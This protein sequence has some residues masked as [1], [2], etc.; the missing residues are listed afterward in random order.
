MKSAVG[1]IT[2]SQMVVRSRSVS[3]FQLMIMVL[4]SGYNSHRLMCIITRTVSVYY[5]HPF[6]GTMMILEPMEWGSARSR[7]SRLTGRTSNEYVVAMRSP[8]M[9]ALYVRPR[10]ATGLAVV[11]DWPVPDFSSSKVSTT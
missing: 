7:A 8:A 3:E 9:R 4:K 2:M 5:S 10:R 6:V 1:T 11:E